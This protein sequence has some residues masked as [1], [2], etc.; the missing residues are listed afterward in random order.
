MAKRMVIGISAAGVFRTDD[1]GESWEPANKGTAADF[2]PEVFEPF[3]RD[4]RS[5]HLRMR[6]REAHAQVVEP[7][8]FGVEP[9]Q[10]ILRR[11]ADDISVARDAAPRGQF[12]RQRWLRGGQFAAES[13]THLLGR[14]R[15][16]EQLVDLLVECADA[17]EIVLAGQAR[18]AEEARLERVEPSLGLGHAGCV[19]LQ[20]RLEEEVRIL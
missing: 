3:H 16:D 2:L 8:S 20:L 5:R 14:F 19:V 12:E 4:P 6:I 13:I 17:R 1:G 7:L 11:R 18:A 9:R 10:R 15:L